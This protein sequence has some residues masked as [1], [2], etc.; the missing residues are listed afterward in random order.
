MSDAANSTVYLTNLLKNLRYYKGL[1]ERAIAQVSDADLHALL[2]PDSNSIAV[3]VQHLA[4]N[5]RS[6][7]TDFLTTDG[8]KPDR[9]RDGEFEMP[10]ALSRRELMEAWDK[11]WTITFAAIERL[12]PADLLRTVYIRG[13]A[14]LA[15]ETLN[16]LA[17]HAAYHV[18]QIV[19]LSKHFAAGEWKTLSIPRR[20]ADASSR[21]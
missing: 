17:L 7:F 19:Y 16:R 14:A 1:G 4:G 13:E 5:L 9:N 12:E 18:G 6:R 2:D 21:Q 20:R 10:D 11:G 8:E 3:I 15:L